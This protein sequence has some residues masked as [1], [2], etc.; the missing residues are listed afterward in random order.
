MQVL[1]GETTDI[2][3]LLCFTFWD[4]VYV[5]RYKSSGF[6]GQVGSLKSS[7]IRGRFVGFAENVGHALTFKVLTDDTQKIIHRSRLRLAEH[8]DNEVKFKSVSPAREYVRS[9]RDAND[10]TTVLPTVDVSVEPFDD[11]SRHEEQAVPEKGET[12]QTKE[13]EHEL[14]YPSPLDDPPL[15]Q[16]PEITTVDEDEDIAPHARVRKPGAP[17]PDNVPIDFSAEQPTPPNPTD[18][19]LTPDEMLDRTFLMPPRDDGSRQRAKILNIIQENKDECAKHPEVVKFKCLVNNEYEDVVAYNDIID[20]IEQDQ[21]WD[22]VW[23]FRKILDHKGPIKPSDPGYKGS[24]YNLK[25]EWETGEITWEP[26]TRVDKQGIWE[27]DPV[28]VAIYAREKNLLNTPGWKLPGLK[29]Y[30]KTQKRMIRHANKAKLH[31]FRTKPMF[32]YGFQVPRNHAQAMELDAANGNTK[33]LDAE[34]I[35]LAQ[36][37]EYDSFIDKGKGYSPGKDYKRINVHLVYAVKHDG[38]HKARLV[39]D[40]HLTETPID[41]VY[42]SVVSLRGIRMITFLAELNG[43]ETWA[44]DIGNAY[45]ESYTKEKVYIIAGPEFGPREGHVLIIQKALY[46]LKSSGLRWHERFADVLRSM[47]FFP[48]KAEPDIWMRDRGDHYEYIGVYVDDLVLCSK[49]PKEIISEL[50]EKHAFKL[51]GTGPISFHLGCDFFRDH[52]EHLCYAPR[53]YIEKM[54]ENYKRLFGTYPKPATSPLV[55]GD[56]PELDASELLDLEGIKIYQSLIGALQWVI[57][58]GRWDIATAVMTLSRFRAAPRQGHLDRAKRI[59]GYLRK[60]KHGVV[61]IDP[62][63]PDHSDVPT[64]E[65]DWERSC[66]PGAKELVPDDVPKPLGKPVLMTHY[67][68]A[69]LMHDLISG[70]SVTG[71]LHMWNNTVIDWYSKLQGTVETA[72]FGSEFVASRTCTE[73]II[74]LRMTARYLGVPIKETSIMFGD[75]ESV[76]NSAS[77]P[78]SKLHKRHNALSYHKTRESI[79]AKITRYVHIPGSTNPADI[80]SKHWD[81]PAIWETLKP[82]LFSSFDKDKDPNGDDSPKDPPQS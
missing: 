40:G 33:W 22:G 78:H 58:I 29:K 47:G 39:A 57:Q 13:G 74:D 24:R 72:T 41:S 82:L 80:L 75:N 45:L 25:I 43:M 20:Y 81:M 63:V 15:S 64:K 76:V 44:T 52:K 50:V 16:Q 67:L 36:I 49:N 73:Q 61:R 60:Y 2:S 62:T 55:K 23:N 32:M 46:G 54:L 6:S 38:R 35:E 3:I 21:T 18:K 10:K 14:E 26:L 8:P 51:K 48:S 68:D 53:K 56:H 37:D 66:Y 42:S 9:K 30:A 79:A 69:N 11:P 27:M 71:I 19:G 34:K 65:Y 59:H 70:R 17:N 77:V 31:S 5:S 7:E 4:V 12:V 28:T 1:T